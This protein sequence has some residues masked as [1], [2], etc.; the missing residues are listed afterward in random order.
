M[1]RDLS[2]AARRYSPL[3]AVALLPALRELVVDLQKLGI[4]L[5]RGA[6]VA[7]AGLADLCE[8]GGLDGEA[9][10]LRRVD[11][12]ELRRRVDALHDGDVRG[13]PAEVAEIHRERRLRCPGHAH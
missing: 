11:L 3:A 5:R 8:P 4:G 9:D 7:D 1:S 10:D 2:T 6:Q 12:E 13:L